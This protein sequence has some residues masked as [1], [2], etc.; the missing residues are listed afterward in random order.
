LFAK[1]RKD[2]QRYLAKK[3]DDKKD[4]QLGMAIDSNIITKGLKY[5][6]ATGNWGANRKGAAPR[7]GVSQ[8]LHRLTFASTL[9]HLRRLNS[10]VGR[11]GKLAKPRQLHNT[12]WGMVCPAETPEGQ[13]CGLVKNLSLMAYITVGSSSALILDFLEEWTMEGL[14]DISPAVIPNAT[15]IFVNGCWVGV[16]RNP[17]YLVS[18]LRSLRRN[19]NL[20]IEVSG[21]SHHHHTT[22]TTTYHLSLL[23]QLIILL[24]SFHFFFCCLTL[25]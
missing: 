10:P 2:C 6:L 12:H 17:D 1:L 3:V 13:A 4:F 8:V 21:A 23:F 18:T 14:E 7:S 11:E 19:V 22:W 25:C 24:S 20:P 15:K 9:S 16:H 5:C